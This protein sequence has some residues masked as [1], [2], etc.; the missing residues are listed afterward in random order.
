[1]TD[2]APA[3]A[4]R[5]PRSQRAAATAPAAARIKP[6]IQSL[7]QAAQWYA[8]LRDERATDADRVAW[9]AWLQ[10]PE[11]QAAWACIDN[12]SRKF[13]PLRGYGPPGT[14]A[15]VASGEA[16]RRAVNARRQALKVIPGVMGL[17]LF[18]L[19]WRYTPLPEV[20]AALRADHHT[21]T[22]K[23]QRLVLTDGSRVWLN[24]RS[25]LDVDY[26]RQE[27]RLI[28]L[29]GEILVQTAQDKLRRPFY[30]DTV[31]GRLQALGTRYSVLLGR[32]STRVDVFEGSMEIRTN[33]GR[34]LQVHDGQAATFDTQ[35][36][37]ALAGADP[38]REAWVHG[39][40]PADHI[41]LA[42]LLAELGR[43]RH[44]HLGVA[45]EVADIRVM[46]VFPTDDT[47]RALAM[48]EQTLPIRVRRRLPWWTTV[49]GR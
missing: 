42:D 10:A 3:E 24:T 14:T 39:V 5:P 8:R 33:A 1:M 38:M 17:G 2:P 41:R 47:D 44:G 23:R 25:A 7:K 48:L 19:G 9:Q 49:E 46:G 35:Q 18:A 36:I 34:T 32:A 11:H 30:V 28:V 20:V 21:G 4:K 13:D 31:H 22:G 29:G 45:P 27:R 37:R 6:G 43:Y 40:V 16:A 15:A 12:V 26:R